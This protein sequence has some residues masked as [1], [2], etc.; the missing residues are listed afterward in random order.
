M[1]QYLFC[2]LFGLTNIHSMLKNLL[3]NKTKV[4]IL[5]ILVL[6]LALI[7]IVEESL[8]YDPYLDYFKSD[9]INLPLP[10]VDKLHL[11]LS[12]LFRYSLNTIVS[13]AFI[14][15]AFKDIN[16]TKFAVVLYGLLF[17]ILIITLWVVLAFYANENKMEL[18][19]IRRFLIQPLFLL[20]FIPGYLIQKRT[21]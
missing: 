1:E 5:G 8:F 10:I 15:I 9:F 17:I 21:N 12:L 2:G 13:I 14:Q 3:N 16:F 19:Y 7:R 20:L 6:F 18:F 4:F 11:F